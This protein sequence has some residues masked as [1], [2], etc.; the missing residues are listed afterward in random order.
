M[1]LIKLDLQKTYDTVWRH[2]VLNIL[3]KWHNNGQMLQFITSF[4]SERSF[5]VKVN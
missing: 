1:M 5:Q 4:L 3:N 2:M